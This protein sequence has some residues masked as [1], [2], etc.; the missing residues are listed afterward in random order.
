MKNL[1]KA[2]YNSAQK[3]E[4]VEGLIHEIIHNPLLTEE[5]R[6]NLRLQLLQYLSCNM[7]KLKFNKDGIPT[8]GKIAGIA[9]ID[10]NAMGCGFCQEMRE[11]AAKFP[12]LKLICQFCYACGQQETFKTLVQ[13]AHK[14]NMRILSEVE[15]TEDE[16][17]TVDIPYDLARAFCRVNE[18]GDTANVIHARNII[19]IMRTHPHIRFAWWYKNRSAVY[20]ALDEMGKPENC[21][22]V[23]SVPTISA[24]IERIRK[25]AGRYDNKVFA[26]FETAEEVDEAVRQGFVKCNGVKCYVC[27]YSCYRHHDG[28]VLFIA[29]QMRKVA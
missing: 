21:E 1:Q 13:M 4:I 8:G 11:L 15:F 26:V 23:F 18:D 9:S 19:R 14:R 3:D 17:A 16:L 2:I 27:G 20:S 25:M 28:G 24:S 12:E 7:H 10:G 29:E 22:I 6:H 5:G